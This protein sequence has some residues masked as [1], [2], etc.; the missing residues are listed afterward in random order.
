MLNKGLK[1]LKSKMNDKVLQV[2]NTLEGINI[3]LNDSE[4]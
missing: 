4:E 1:Y 2:K 3:R